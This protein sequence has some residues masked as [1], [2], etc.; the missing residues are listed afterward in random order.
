MTS[1]A[2]AGALTKTGSPT[3]VV[4]G[5]GS[6]VNFPISEYYYNTFPALNETPSAITMAAILH[7]L[8]IM[9]RVVLSLTITVF[10]RIW[11]VVTLY[12]KS[13]AFIY[14]RLYFNEF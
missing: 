12:R 3:T 13:K 10:Q 4:N 2:Q 1:V 14:N 5:Y 9:A 11:I 6:A 7:P 8:A